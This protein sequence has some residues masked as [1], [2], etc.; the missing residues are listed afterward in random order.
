MDARY[1]D[2]SMRGRAWASWEVAPVGGMER[3]VRRSLSQ[4]TPLLAPRLGPA[5]AP[6]R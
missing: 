2:V 3:G 5:C 1:G 6:A 4:L